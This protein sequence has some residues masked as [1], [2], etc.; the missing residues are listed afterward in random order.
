MPIHDKEISI[1]P[2]HLLDGFTAEPHAREWVW[3]VLHTRPRQEKAVARALH[4]AETAFYLPL[5]AKEN[6]IRGRTIH[7]YVPV[8]ASYVFLF[9]SDEDRHRALKTNRVAYT[10]DVLDQPMLLND[11]RQIRRLIELDAPLTV[12]RRIQPGQWVRV[13]TGPLQGLEGS[14]VSRRGKTRLMIVLRML[15]QGVS[16]QID[17]VLLEPI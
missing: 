4:A 10:L 12:E 7:S 17:D 9:G 2:E 16:V 3:W 5:V 6:V 11:L 15:Q 13:R 8:F 14:V 1:Y